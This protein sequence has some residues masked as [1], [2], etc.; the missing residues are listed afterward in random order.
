MV[1]LRSYDLIVVV[2]N[3][4][5]GVGPGVKVTAGV[6]L[7]ARSLLPPNRPVLIESLIAIDARGVVT[8]RLANIVDS[9]IAMYLTEGLSI[10]RGVVGAKV[11]HDVVLDERIPHPT[12]DGEVAVPVGLV[13]TRV[14]N[15]S[16]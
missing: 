16:V 2:S 8:G 7:P 9:I 4:K 5:A 11:L 3:G 10:R 14:F 12:V 1:S 13:G 6:D 15:S